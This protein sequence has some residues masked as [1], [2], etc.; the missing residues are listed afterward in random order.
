[1]RRRTFIASAALPFVASPPVSAQGSAQNAAPEQRKITLAMGVWMIDFLPLV[2]ADTLGLFKQQGMDVTVQNFSQGGS[3]SLQALMGGSADAVV[4][5]YDHTIQMQA[6]RR[7]IQAVALMNPLPGL[8]L[9]VRSD[10]A[11]HVKDVHD[12]K[13]LKL[14]VTVPGAAGDYLM[15]YMLRNAGMSPTDV[16]FV[17]V[18]SG[19]NCVAAVEQKQVDLVLNYDPAMTVLERRG[20]IKIMIDT[21][22][23]AGTQSAYGGKYPFLCLYTMR[24]FIER[25]PV[26]V[27]RLTNALVGGLRYIH[28]H[29]SEQIADALPTSYL[30]NDRALF[31]NILDRSR[32]SFSPDGR[33]DPEALKTPLRVLTTFDERIAKAKIDLSRTYTNRF[34]DAV[35][36]KG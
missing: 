15:K 10:L 32:Q 12:F 6:Q 28:D 21:R 33:F 31:I 34:V 22:T 24:D 25:N 36:T 27:Q 35:A 4:A 8:V 14:G 20:S 23:E 7:D 9:G 30:Q 11:E 17:A 16:A 3:A 29:S 13:G 18:G 5:S 19:A 2:L 1:M 26:S